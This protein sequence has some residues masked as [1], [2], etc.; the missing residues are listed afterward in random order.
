MPKTRSEKQQR[1]QLVSSLRT[2]GASWIE[3]AA[4]LQQRYR[5][6][7]RVALRYAHGWSQR[8]AADEW[9]KRWPDELKTFKSFHTGSSGPAV[10]AMPPR[11]TISP[12]SQNCTGA[13][14]VICLVTCRISAI[15]IH[16]ATQVCIVRPTTY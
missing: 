5:L 9:N 16:P 14:S 11:S 10:P 7:A 3:V 15:L 6:N 2:S 13:L 12:D 1:D 8:Q 4:E